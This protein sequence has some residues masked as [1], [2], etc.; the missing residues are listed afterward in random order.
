MSRALS[1]ADAAKRLGVSREFAYQLLGRGEF[2]VPAIRL[3]RLWKIPEAPLEAFLATGHAPGQ[4]T[5]GASPHSA[6][7]S[8]APSPVGTPAAA[9][10]VGA[11]IPPT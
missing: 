8:P 4:S 1:V 7:G 5:H 6:M 9:T 3:G 11:G 2:P 10:G